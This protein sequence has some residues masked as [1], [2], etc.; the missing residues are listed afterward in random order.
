MN[1]LARVGVP[2][3]P[4]HGSSEVFLVGWRESGVRPECWFVH[5][6]GQAGEPFQAVPIDGITSDTTGGSERLQALSA[7]ARNPYDAN[8]IYWPERDGPELIEGV[9]ALSG[10]RMGGFCQLTIVARD[11]ISMRILRRWP[12]HVALPFNTAPLP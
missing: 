12:E 8:P 3:G 11:E 2:L 5:A 10:E 1:D 9:R 4:E 7:S 6:G